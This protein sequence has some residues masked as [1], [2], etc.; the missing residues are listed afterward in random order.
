M[1]GDTGLGTL[2][3]VAASVRCAPTSSRCSTSAATTRRPRSGSPACA[4]RC[5]RRGWRRPRS[6]ARRETVGG[7]LDLDVLLGKLA[8]A[9]AR[10]LGADAAAVWV[11]DATSEHNRVAA[12]YGFDDDLQGQQFPAGA[13]AAGARSR[14]LRPVQRSG[15]EPTP[16]APSLERCAASWP[17]RCAGDAAGAA[18][19]SSP[20]SLTAAFGLAEIELGAP[21]A[22]SRRWPS[23]TP[24]PFAERGPPGPARS[25]RVPGRR[26]P[27]RRRRTERVRSRRSPAWPRR[28]SRPTGP[29]AVRRGPPVVAGHGAAGASTRAGAP[30]DRER[31]VVAAGNVAEDARLSRRARAPRWGALLCVPLSGDG[32]ASG[33]CG[34]ARGTRPGP[35]AT[36]SWRWP[37]ACTSR[38]WPRSSVPSSRRPSTG[39]HAGARAAAGRRT[40]RRRPRAQTV[41]RQIVAAGH[42]PARRRRLHP[43]AARGRRLSPARC[44]ARPPT[45]CPCGACRPT[46]RSRPRC[47]RAPSPWPSPT[48]RRPRVADEPLRDA[49]FAGL[50]GAPVQR[51]TARSRACW[52]ST[53]ARR[54]ACAPTRSTAWQRSPARRRSRCETRCCTS[55]WPRRRTRARRSSPRWPT[56]SWRPTPTT[57]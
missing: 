40:A 6:C 35:S 31:R 43:A 37:S 22:G 56:P 29:G 7:E 55:G 1:L 20:R 15:G 48:S 52:P 27:R 23:R 53:P 14:G 12:S 16:S 32:R 9:S 21:S 3:L 50:L 28:R 46:T 18:R 26:R 49:G 47:S 10:M 34:D 4:P 57:A 51:P 5:A 38:R 8:A 44:T 45:S 54:G 24:R 17:S 13:G 42:R 19:S 41:L 33:R 2:W 25:G 36:R 30:A 39:R 11:H